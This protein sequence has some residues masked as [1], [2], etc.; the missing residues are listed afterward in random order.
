MVLSDWSS[1]RCSAAS[2]SQ[3]VVL[4]RGKQPLPH[5]DPELAMALCSQ[6]T[7]EGI[8]L[9]FGAEMRCGEINEHGKHIHIHGE[10]GKDEDI[11]SRSAFGGSGAATR[12]GRTQS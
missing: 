3:V 10:D 12:V 6:L 11:G 9:E 2:A 4:E 7:A 8:R 5:E 1:R